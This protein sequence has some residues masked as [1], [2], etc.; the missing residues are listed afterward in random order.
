M[1]K[2]LFKTIYYFLFD[3][4]AFFRNFDR[5]YNFI[6]ITPRLLSK[7]IKKTFIF[8][9][10]NKNFFVQ[11]VRN[12]FDLITINEIF[13]EEN[14]NLKKFKI[15]EK[16]S[17]RYNSYFKE[18]IKPLIIDCG[19]NIGSSSEYFK[20]C[21]VNVELVMIEPDKNN[22]EFSKKNTSINEKFLIN[23]AISSEEKLLKFSNTSNDNR[24]YKIENDGNVNIESITIENIL[25]I[26][27]NEFKPFLIKIDIEGFEKDLFM[28]NIQWMKY[29]DIIIIELHD[30][31]LP[32]SNNSYNFIKSINEISTNN[33]NFDILISGENLVF[34]KNDVNK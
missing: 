24:A 16:I 6:V 28:K 9:K 34:I 7:I 13:V 27:K 8:D 2:N 4:L 23:K 33:I 20:R 22:L 18:N 31:M 14:Y 30:W 19:S 3:I 32:G 12:D 17:K 10:T 1:F 11:H 25:N 21:F 26:T 15:W 29:F 5:K